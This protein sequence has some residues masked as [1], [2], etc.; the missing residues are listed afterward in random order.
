MGWL[1]RNNKWRDTVWHM[2][3]VSLS[4]VPA[5]LRGYLS[6]YL[7]EIDTNV[8]VGN[9]STKVRE[10]LWRRIEEL[11]TGHGRAI[12][13][14]PSD[15]E[16]GFDFKTCG[17]A[18]SIIDFEGLKLVRR[19]TERILSA[20]VTPYEIKK[21]SKRLYRESYV[22]LDLETT[23]LDVEKDRILE[24]GAVKVI[25]REVTDTF[26]C[27]IKTEAEIPDEITKLTGITQKEINLGIPLADA[28]E[29]LKIFVGNLCV[30]GYN[31]VNY[32]ARILHFECVRNKVEYP[33]IRIIDVLP[34][35]RQAIQGISSY[36]LS[37]VADCLNIKSTK[38]HR[39]LAD[40]QICNEIYQMLFDN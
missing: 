37:D 34:I 20:A 24:I 22:V 11:V 2:I 9:V 39:A 38:I 1:S 7:W 33:F 36:S 15:S 21:T 25:D 30:I 28:I 27:I 3:V 18:F 35:A 32:D 10:L 17:T 19:P 12:M 31:I 5:K 6:L 14:Y 29:Q 4:T 23:G 13:V 26:E 40:C 8:Y 16:Q